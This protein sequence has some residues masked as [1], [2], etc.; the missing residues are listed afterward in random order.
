MKN[1]YN[2]LEVN[3]ELIAQKNRA[4]FLNKHPPY[5]DFEINSEVRKLCAYGNELK[6]LSI[7][8]S[9]LENYFK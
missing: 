9:N 5:V 3:G 1:D 7:S 2:D 8:W 6:I 4:G